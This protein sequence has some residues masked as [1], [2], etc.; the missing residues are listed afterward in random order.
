MLGPISG[1]LQLQVLS[2][3]WPRSWARRGGGAC[4]IGSRPGGSCTASNQ[5]ASHRGAQAPNEM[6]LQAEQL[7]KAT[8]DRYKIERRHVHEFRAA[9]KLWASGLTW[10][11]SLNIVREALDEVSHA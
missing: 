9:A 6:G 1:A 7:K 11:E 3:S 2:F 5:F 8:L 4:R 10:T